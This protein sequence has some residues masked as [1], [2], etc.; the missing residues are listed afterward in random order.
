MRGS[1]IDLLFRITQAL[2]GENER[3]EP[4]LQAV[5]DELDASG[6]VRGAI[7][8]LDSEGDEARIVVSVGHSPTQI[9]RGRFQ[10]GTGVIGQ[11]LADGQPILIPDIEADPTWKDTTGARTEVDL[12]GVAYLCVPI[13]TSRDATTVGTLSVDRLE[14]DDDGAQSDVQLLAIIAG[15]LGDAVVSWRDRREEREALR[16]ENLRLKKASRPP[17][18]IIGTHRTMHQVF[19][20][21]DHVAASDTT[22]LVRGE[23]GTGKELVARAIHDRSSRADSRFV[24]VNCGA[25]PENLV[26]SELFGH[27]RGAYTGA[28]SNRAGRFEM[29]HGG[30]IFLDEI[31]ELPPQMQV[32][33]LRVLQEGEIQKVGEDRPQRVDVRVVAATN[34][35][36]EEGMAAG[37][38]REDLY[39]RLNIFPIYLPSL[40]DRKSDITL[41]ADHFVEK[42]SDINNQPVVRVTTPAIELMYAYHWPGNVRELENCIARAVLLSEDGTIRSHHLPPTLQTGRS[43]GTSN[44]GSLDEMMGA[45]EREILIE[46]MK[47]ADGV[48][49]RAACALETTPRILAYRLKRHDLHGQLVRARRHTIGQPTTS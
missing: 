44:S 32:K 42:Y 40:R 20:L 2:L 10:K 8:L 25:L 22:V 48:L 28:M 7:T 1:E 47:D 16:N 14:G 24:S 3:L 45:Y 46:A 27:V 6:L 41:L 43:S 9:E 26:E 13:L 34:I 17:P 12:E 33:L 49:A 35:D 11:V 15:L 30:T 21:I 37:A 39:Y 29:A 31:A 18:N 23:S 38:F 5:L 19:K 36:L 4:T